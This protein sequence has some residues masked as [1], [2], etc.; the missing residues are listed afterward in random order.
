MEETVRT[1]GKARIATR[2]ALLLS[3]GAIAAALIAAIGTA[4][5]AWTFRAGLGALRY[6]FF[7]A[8]GGALV[9]LIALFLARRERQ[10]RLVWANAIALVAALG[11][12]T[13]LGAKVRTAR[14]VPAI[15]DISTNLDDV[16]QFSR[17]K[18]RSD[19]LEKVPDLDKPELKA[20]A[21]E[22]RWKAVHRSAYGDIQPIH[23]PMSV[24]DSTRRAEALA[25]ERGWQ[26]QRS[27][28][29]AGILEATATSFFFRFKD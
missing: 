14:S 25:R 12:L 19:N 18:V 22:E 29:A 3:L 10:S 26:I 1:G 15:H 28:P 11:F 16:P 20:M 4:S 7:A 23:V 27:D 24:E 2:I 8:A 6:C 5:G 9:A 21:P 13:Y 17:V